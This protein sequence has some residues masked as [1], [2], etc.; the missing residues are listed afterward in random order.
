M[1]KA[2]VDCY[3]AGLFEVLG[4]PLNIVHDDVSLNNVGNNEALAEVKHIMENTIQWKVPILVE[5]EDGPSW[6]TVKK[7]K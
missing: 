6:G 1:K 5:R 2:L 4:Y 3:A 7:V